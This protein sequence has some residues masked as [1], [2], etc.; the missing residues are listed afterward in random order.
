MDRLLGRTGDERTGRTSPPPRLS[1]SRTPPAAARTSTD[2]TARP[3]TVPG[4]R[5][6]SGPAATP[7]DLRD[8]E[9]N[10]RWYA[11]PDGNVER[12]IGE[13]GLP[14]VHLVR[15]GQGEGMVL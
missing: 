10:Q 3:A 14:I 6:A 11:A 1:T 2:P 9:N 15:Y 7:P 13:A 4:A 5:P 12:F 8:D